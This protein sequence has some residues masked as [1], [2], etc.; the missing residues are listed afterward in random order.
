MAVFKNNVPLIT[1]GLVYYFDAGNINSVVSGSTTAIDLTR[2]NQNGVFTN[3]TSPGNGTLT[4]NNGF[5][6]IP[7]SSAELNSQQFSIVT[8]FRTSDYT[9]QQGLLEKGA[10]E[11]TQFGFRIEGNNLTGYIAQSGSLTNT[12]VV[13]MHYINTAVYKKTK[14][15][16]SVYSMATFTYNSGSGL[17]KMY[18]GDKLT[19]SQAVNYTVNISADTFRIGR[20]PG[21]STNFPF[22]GSFAA[23]LLYNRELS[24]TEVRTLMNTIYPR[25]SAIPITPTASLV[26]TNLIMDLNMN[27]PNS[28]SG[29]GS[30]W[31]DLQ[32]NY[33]FTLFNSPTVVGVDGAKCIS[34]N[35]SNTYAFRTGS[36]SHNIGSA[37]TINLV[38]GDWIGTGRAM[39]VCQNPVNED[40]LSYF[41]IISSGATE[42]QSSTIQ[43]L[44]TAVADLT[45]PQ[46]KIL[47]YTW[48]TGSGGAFYVNSV[49]VNTKSITG[50]TSANVQRMAFGANAGSLSEN[51]NVRIAEVK[52]YDRKLTDAEVLQNYDALK[53]TYGLT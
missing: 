44:G 6:T 52:M 41:N 49:K 27:N 40:Y 31:V 38:I 16:H 33:N 2:K 39:S 4:F 3:V 9:A 7:T 5:I 34:F 53:T 30:T 17:V 35:G 37:C 18:Y 26:T 36:I 48:D 10:A 8:I 19:K 24:S 46:Y 28:Y 20:M 50:F 15:I 47:T 13:G 12:N 23:A 11:R 45:L 21:S 22:T 42:G 14:Q 25:Y 32:G 51:G 43:N 29:T 1:D